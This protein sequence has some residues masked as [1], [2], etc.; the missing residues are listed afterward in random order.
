MP[1]DAREGEVRKASPRLPSSPCFAV[2]TR[3]IARPPSL[4]PLVSLVE[5]TNERTNKRTNERVPYH[6]YHVYLSSRD[7]VREDIDAVF[8]LEHMVVA[9]YAKDK[10]LL[11][12]LFHEVCVAWGMARRARMRRAMMRV[13]RGCV[14][15]GCVSREDASR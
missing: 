10:M 14:A 9:A 1:R 15:R 6:A 8:D 7:E 3:F 12:D 5:R 4:S 11:V 2:D 13:A